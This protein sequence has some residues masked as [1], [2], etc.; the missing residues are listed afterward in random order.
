MTGRRLSTSHLNIVGTASVVALLCAPVGH[1]DS[2]ARISVDSNGRQGNSFSAFPAVSG[3]GRFVAFWS[4]SGNLV[5]GDS[6]DAGDVFVHDRDSGETTIASVSSNG[7][8]GNGESALPSLSRNGRFVAF[9][10]AADNL[11]RSDYNFAGDVFVH[12]RERQITELVSISNTGEQAN[13]GSSEDDTPGISGD[14]RYVVFSSNADN[15]VANDYNG[16]TDVFVYDRKQDVVRRVSVASDGTEADGRSTYPAISGDGRFVT[17]RSEASSLVARDTNAQPDIFVHDLASGTT[18]RVSV[19]GNGGQSNGASSRPTINGNGRY[20]AFWS[21]ADNLVGD[22]FNGRSDAFV[23][24]L[25]SGGTTRV[26]VDSRGMEGDGDSTAPSISGDGRLIAFRS[27]ANNLVANDRNGVNDIFLHD[28]KH[29][30][31]IRVSV[32]TQGSDADGVSFEP[33]ISADSRYITFASSAGN[34]VP[35]D[36]NRVWDVFSYD[37]AEPMSVD[38]K[39]NDPR[40]RVSPMSEVYVG[41]ML[42]STQLAQNEAADLDAPQIDPVTV[43]IGPGQAT[44]SARPSRIRDF[45]ADGDRDL[46]LPVYVPQLQLACDDKQIDVIAETFEGKLQVGSDQM[47]AVGCNE[48]TVEMDFK[49]NDALNRVAPKV[50]GLIGVS[51][52]STSRSMGDRVNFDPGYVDLKSI[53]LGPNKAKPQPKTIL[54]DL[55]GDGDEDLVLRFR[56]LDLGLSCNDASVEILGT[57]IQGAPFTAKAAI[58]TSRC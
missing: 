14:G 41:V 3:D 38:F 18:K 58:R 19:N 32:G 27:D 36:T 51:L 55:D 13:A 10:S 48:K 17:F 29:G 50:N 8:L 23:H 16:V 9:K 24:D 49:P 22:D 47:S 34:L 45:D 44:A 31:T 35:G 43:R 37:R 21:A 15:L 2:S 33:A 11:V 26:S 1:A 52:V 42:K 20:V 7:Q 28:R 30:S 39:P 5:A 46:I 6:N 53:Q 54:R 12:D 40:N 57:T 25:Q 56:V 4:L